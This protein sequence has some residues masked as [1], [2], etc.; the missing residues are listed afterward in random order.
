MRFCDVLCVLEVKNNFFYHKGQSTT[1]RNT[2]GRTNKLSL[3]KS[4]GA[5]ERF[6]GLIMNFQ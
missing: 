5:K 4:N 3:F 2:K 6:G 1:L